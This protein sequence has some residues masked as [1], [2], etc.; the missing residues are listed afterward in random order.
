[1]LTQRFQDARHRPWALLS[2]TVLLGFAAQAGAQ[3]SEGGETTQGEPAAAPAAA[4]AQAPDASAAPEQAPAPPPSDGEAAPASGAGALPTE[5]PPAPP[6][7]AGDGAATAA[8]APAT[9]A[10]P[11][12]TSAR[13]APQRPRAAAP[14]PP[15]GRELPTQEG[16][17]LRLAGGVGFPFGPDIADSYRELPEGEL[18][19]TGYAAAF[20]VMAGLF[21]MPWLAVGAGFVSDAIAA[22]N[23]RDRFEDDR[24]IQR[25]LYHAIAGGFADVYFGGTKEGV[26]LQALVG[27]ALLSPAFNLRRGESGPGIALAAGYEGRVS[28]RWNVGGLLRVAFASFGD[29]TF[30]GNARSPR[31]YQPTL[32]LT[33]TFVP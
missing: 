22:G 7:D 17:Y 21:A 13:P 19:F 27:V 15:E 26:H 14:R 18:R 32:L 8:P 4:P 24:A 1:M 6:A 23:I 11:A 9:T 12:V 10:A 20:D 5:V 16:F 33:T 30:D 25:S 2:A 29:H 3:Q 28:K 31:L